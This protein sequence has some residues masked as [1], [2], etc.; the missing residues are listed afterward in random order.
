VISRSKPAPAQ[1]GN[2]GASTG[3]PAKRSF[4]QEAMTRSV[5]ANAV[6]ATAERPGCGFEAVAAP[7]T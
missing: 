3:F 5:E 2:R 1:H 6:Y 4:L 7:A